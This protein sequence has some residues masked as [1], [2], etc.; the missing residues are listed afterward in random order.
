MLGAHWTAAIAASN[1]AVDARELIR[2][3]LAE[4]RVT[5][6]QPIPA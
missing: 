3:S 5:M 2:R 1:N 6:P 4:N